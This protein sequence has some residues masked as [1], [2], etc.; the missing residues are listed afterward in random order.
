MKCVC[1][2]SQR[3]SVLWLGRDLCKIL[4]LLYSI[5]SYYLIPTVFSLF[6]YAFKFTLFH[7]I[8]FFDADNSHFIRIGLFF[9]SNATL[10][11]L[12]TWN[13]DIFYCVKETGVYSCPF[14]FKSY[15]LFII[16]LVTETSHDSNQLSII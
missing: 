13:F 8:A 16:I 5:G 9:S 7:F 1:M 11:K 2:L 15:K 6:R 12:D 4:R 14:Y 10:W 3:V